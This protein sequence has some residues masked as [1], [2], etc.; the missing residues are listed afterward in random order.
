[1]GLKAVRQCLVPRV[2]VI[3]VVLLLVVFVLRPL[4]PSTW[5]AVPVIALLVTP[6]RLSLTFTSLNKR[7]ELLLVRL[8]VV[9]KVLRRTRG[10][11]LAVRQRSVLIPVVRGRSTVL[12]PVLQIVTALMTLLW[13]IVLFLFNRFLWRRLTGAWSVLVK[14]RLESRRII[15]VLWRLVL[16]FPAKFRRSFLMGRSTGWVQWRWRFITL[17]LMVLILVVKVLFLTQWWNRVTVSVMNRPV[18]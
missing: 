10:V 9:Q 1:M 2:T 13:L 14:P 17:F 11:I 3:S 5:R 7:S 12:L 18:I 15:T 16:R 8:K 6:V 4:S